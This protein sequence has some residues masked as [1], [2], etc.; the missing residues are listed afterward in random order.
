MLAECP[1]WAMVV[2]VADILGQHGAQMML[3]HD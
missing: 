3:A 2:V 1:V